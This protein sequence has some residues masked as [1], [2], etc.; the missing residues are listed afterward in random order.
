VK[1]EILPATPGHIFTILNNLRPRE[2]AVCEL[3]YGEQFKEILVREYSQSLLTF[4]GLIDGKVGAVWGVR[5]H[6]VFSREGYVWLIGTR[7]VDEHPVVFLRHSRRLIAELRGIYT[8]LFGCV[9]TDYLEGR[10]WLEWLGFEIGPDQGGI[11]LCELKWQ[12]HH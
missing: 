1:V 11:C 9:V 2:A 12:Q 3:M 7:L 6:E 10:K 8:A 4:V 5:T